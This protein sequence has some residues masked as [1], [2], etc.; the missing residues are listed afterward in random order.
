MTTPQA[1]RNR[2]MFVCVYRVGGTENFQWIACLPVDSRAKAN[3]QKRE[4]ENGGRKAY[5]YN[6]AQ[7]LVIG[8]PET[9]E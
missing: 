9:Y 5:V 7:Y 6:Y 2:K 3:E 1:D 4:I 8:P